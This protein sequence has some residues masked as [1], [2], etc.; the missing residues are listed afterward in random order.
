[1]PETWT[2]TRSTSRSTSQAKSKVDLPIFPKQNLSCG[3]RSQIQAEEDRGS[4]LGLRASE[5]DDSGPSGSWNLGPQSLERAPAVVLLLPGGCGSGGVPVVQEDSFG[6]CSASNLFAPSVGA[7]LQPLRSSFGRQTSTTKFSGCPRTGLLGPR[8]L[9]Y[10][11]LFENKKL[12]RYFGFIST[13]SFQKL[14]Q[15]SVSPCKR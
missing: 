9:I 10:D 11:Y 7:G 3:S 4:D 5:S 12:L 2:V 1:M 13:K 15:S 14:R 6:T 8:A